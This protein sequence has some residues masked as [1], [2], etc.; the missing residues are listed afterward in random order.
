M[1]VPKK[2][3]S[4]A[5]RNQRRAH[6]ALYGPWPR[7]LPQLRRAA[8]AAQ[9]L[10]RV[11]L[12]QGPYRGR[13]RRRLGRVPAG[14]ASAHRGRRPRRRQRPARDRRR[15]RLCRWRVAARRVRPGRETGSHR[16]RAGR[17]S[18]GEHL[19]APFRRRRGDGRGA[20]GDAEG[21]PRREHRRGAPGWSATV[22]LTRCSPRVTP[23]ATVAAALLR[24]GRLE[25]CRQAGHRDHAP[26]PFAGHAARR[27]GHGLLPAARPLEF[28]YSWGRVRETL[29]RA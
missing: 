3:T 5:R 9:G 24:M 16:A 2:K 10:P 29:L 4:R 12:L 18:P 7:G 22:R 27:G 23:G 17:R 6:H 14:L 11:R 8:R 15:R 25:G 21:Q 28:R 1:A 20:F 19:A 26:F 13:R